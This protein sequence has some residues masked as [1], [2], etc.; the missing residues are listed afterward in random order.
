MGF[1]NQFPGDASNTPPVDKSFSNGEH[2]E[3][4]KSGQ[5][6]VEKKEEENYDEDV[7]EMKQMVEL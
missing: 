4:I 1:Y 6:M 3:E 7:L 5:G 2:P